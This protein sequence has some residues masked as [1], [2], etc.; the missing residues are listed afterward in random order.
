[1]ADRLHHAIDVVGRGVSIRSAAVMYGVPRSTLGEHIGGKQ[2]PGGRSGDPY[3]TLEEEEELVSFLVQTATI[4]YPHTINDVLCVVQKIVEKKGRNV[5]VS[6]GWLDRFCE[7]RPQLA[8][9]M[10]VSLNHAWAIAIQTPTQLLVGN[11]PSGKWI[12]E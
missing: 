4:G 6:M 1:M 9:K 5:V 12:A 10:A 2:L 7:R 3:L 11:V 8:L